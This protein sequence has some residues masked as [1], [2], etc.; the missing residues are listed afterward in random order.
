MWKGRQIAKG[1]KLSIVQWLKTQIQYCIVHDSF[2][3]A[4]I[5]I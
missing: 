2:T 1:F 5:S 3:R 4:K